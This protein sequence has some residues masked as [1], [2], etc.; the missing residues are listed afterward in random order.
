MVERDYEREIEET[1]K[2]VKNLLSDSFLDEVEGSSIVIQIGSKAYELKPTGKATDDIEEIVRAEMKQ[3][4]SQK[5]K[6][7]GELI[8]GKINEITKVSSDYK[9]KLVEKINE[10]DTRINSVTVMPEIGIEHAEK[11]LSIVRGNRPGSI[12][13]LVR[14]VYWPKTITFNHTEHTLKPSLSRKMMV[15]VMFYIE[16]DSDQSVIEVSTRKLMNLQYFPHY[17]QRESEGDCWGTWNP[18]GDCR[19]PDEAIR[20]ARK[21]EKILENINTHSVTEENPRG[22]PNMEYLKRHTIVGKEH[23]TPERAKRMG[24]DERQGD[25]EPVWEIY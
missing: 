6:N 23:E 4:V 1:A 21:A 24:V 7:M 18:P 22:F 2:E 12:V 13:Y 16:V 17:H 14:G 25:N 3:N 9:R 11:G 15:P 5:L 20:I 10:Y 8:S 19:T